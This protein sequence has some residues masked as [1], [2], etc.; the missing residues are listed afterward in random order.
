[1]SRPLLAAFDFDHT[2]CDDNSDVVARKLYPNDN[3]PD[4]VKRLYKGDNWTIYMGKIFELLNENSIDV[5]TIKSAINR[6]PPVS[7]IDTLLTELHSRDCEI[8]IISDSNSAFI[9][10][11]LNHKGLSHTVKQIFTNPATV[12][13]ESGIL[14][15]EMYHLQDYCKLSN[16]NL[17]KGQILE[18]YIS[19]RSSDGVYFEKVAYVGDGK[20]DYCPI[21]RLSEKDVAFPRLG[22]TLVNILNKTETETEANDEMKQVKADVVPWESG[23]DILEDLKKRIASS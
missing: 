2:I 19:K 7:G 18:D 6:I 20:N 8:I 21:L 4:S 17:C 9:E 15:I 22:Y 1:M 10:W 14:K 16:K 5:E 3:L 13:K 11:W 23:E 12:D